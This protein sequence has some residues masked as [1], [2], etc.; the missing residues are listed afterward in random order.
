MGRRPVCPSVLPDVRSIFLPTIKRH[1]TCH[2]LL[3]ATLCGLQHT[4]RSAAAR[5]NCLLTASARTCRTVRQLLPTE[6]TGVQPTMLRPSLH[7]GGRFVFGSKG[8]AETGRVLARPGLVHLPLIFHMY[9]FIIDM[10]VPRALC[11]EQAAACPTSSR[12]LAD[13]VSVD[14]PP[15]S[16]PAFAASL[17]PK[18]H[19][20]P[21]QWVQE[22]LSHDEYRFTSRERF[23]PPSA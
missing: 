1:P 5:V 3:P 20:C 13:G 10:Q 19:G 16:T 4:S 17:H 14:S 6:N 23:R 7:Q 12:T 15:F 9:F 2:L 18:H 11:L 22:V 21:C 8:S